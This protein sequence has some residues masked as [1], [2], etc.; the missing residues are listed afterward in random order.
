MLPCVLQDGFYIGVDV[1]Y[2][3]YRVSDQYNVGFISGDPALSADGIVGGAFFGY[4]R[5]LPSFH[6]L[7][8][9]VEAFGNGSAAASSYNMNTAS[10]SFST[11]VKGK[12]SFG[13]SF[14]PGIRLARATML[15][16][17]FGYNGSKMDVIEKT[18]SLG[19]VTADVETTPIVYGLSYGL[20]IENTFF[21]DF[22]LRLEYTYAHYQS[23]KT[24]LGTKIIADNN[25]LML[26]LLYH[27]NL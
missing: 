7:Y 4:G 21:D 5:Y 10:A 27:I 15:Y 13:I 20:G 6:H 3:L 18:T 23:F 14:L 25:E 9:G 16:A 24:D 11:D 19:V 2:D 22:S 26:G 8:I 17:R 12:N 1:G